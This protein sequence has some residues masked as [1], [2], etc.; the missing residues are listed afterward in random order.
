[1]RHWASNQDAGRCRYS[2]QVSSITRLAGRYA[3]RTSCCWS[4]HY[5]A[6]TDGASTRSHSI[7]ERGQARA[8]CSHTCTRTAGRY[9]SRAGQGNRL[10][11]L[12]NRDTRRCR[13]GRVVGTI[14][15][16]IGRHTARTGSYRSSSRHRTRC[17]IDCAI[18]RS[19]IG[20]RGQ[21]RAS[22]SRAATCTAYR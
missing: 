3:A 20:E 22:C 5:T 18:T 19:S 6:S 15:R 1:M 2:W 17:A 21:A 10:A 14:A 16:L 11:Q 8:C 12:G 7:S 13:C 9:R 4:S